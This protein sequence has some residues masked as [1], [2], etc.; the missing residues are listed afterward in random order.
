LIYEGEKLLR[1]T[2]EHAS[3]EKLAEATGR[4]LPEI[5]RVVTATA[6]RRFE[7]ED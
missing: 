6:N 3:C 7:L 2:P 4:P 1:I 5:Y